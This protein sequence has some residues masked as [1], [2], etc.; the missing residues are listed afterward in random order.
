MADIPLV[1]TN[2]AAAMQGDAIIAPGVKVEHGAEIELDDQRWRVG[3]GYHSAAEQFCHEITQTRL[4]A[5]AQHTGTRSLL[6]KS[7]GQWR[8]YSTVLQPQ[9][10]SATG[11]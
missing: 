2:Y 7:N 9:S 6:C 4:T 3:P 1:H 5:S 8:R 11:L 10:S